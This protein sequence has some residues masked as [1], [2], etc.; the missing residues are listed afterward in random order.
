MRF[1]RNLASLHNY[2]HPPR[3]ISAP[4]HRPRGSGQHSWTQGVRSTTEGEKRRDDWWSLLQTRQR[5]VFPALRCN[6]SRIRFNTSSIY[7]ANRFFGTFLTQESTVLPSS[8]VPFCTPALYI[9]SR[10]NASRGTGV[11]YTRSCGSEIG[12]A[13]CRER[14]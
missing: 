10:E 4:N 13:S 3:L 11:F 2:C 7:V 1:S 9:Q 8:P 12:R 14:V 5:K 6:Q